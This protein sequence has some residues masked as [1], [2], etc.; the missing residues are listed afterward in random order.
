MTPLNDERLCNITSTGELERRWA[1]VRAYMADEKIDA[2]VVHG[3]NGYTGAPGYFRWLTGIPVMNSYPQVA[4]FPRDDL[5]RLI[6]HGDFGG[7]RDNDPATPEFRGVGQRLTTPSFPAIAYAATY[8]ADIAAQAIRAAR[9]TRIGLVG[10]HAMYH[11]FVH[12]L[13]AELGG[14]QVVDCT[15]VVDRFKA[16]KSA[17]DI[18]FIRQTAQMQD[19]ILA[20]MGAYVRP[21]MKDF[22]VMAH[23]QYLGQMRGSEGGYML[24]TSA[25]AGQPAMLRHRPFQGREIRDGDMFMFQAENSG[26]GGFFVHLGRMFVIG[27]APQELVDAFG[28]V[29]EAQ[30]YTL[31]LLQPG[32]PCREI[33]AQYNSYLSARGLATEKRLHCHGQGYEVVERPLIRDDE[34]MAIAAGMNIGIHPAIAGARSFI[35]VCD[36]FMLLE[37]GG[38]ERLHRTEQRIFEV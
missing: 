38:A 8:E 27:K 14:V 33:F 11:G 35:T 7:C 24:G 21:G 23:A 19:D 13:L 6:H 28:Q 34:P 2:L 1:L 4:I 26:P 22:E 16:F 37:G 15:D 36:N 30:Q 29:L 10:A 12:R 3:S 5:M 18:A 25:P 31:G 17:Q 32:V 9:Y 20:A